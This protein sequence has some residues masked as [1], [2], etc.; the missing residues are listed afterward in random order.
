MQ[1]RLYIATATLLVVTLAALGCHDDPTAPTGPAP[2]E[3]S[4]VLAAATPLSFWQVSGGNPFTCAI[5]AADSSA[6]CWG[7]NDHGELGTGS[8]TGP[9]QCPSAIGP[10]ACSTR[11][12]KVATGTRK[13]RSIATGY[14]HACAVTTD[15]HVWCWGNNDHGQLGAGSSATGSATPLAV[16]GSRRFRQVDA[17][18]Y[19]TCGVSYPD[20][21][22]FCWGNN[23]SGQLGDGTLSRRSAPVATLGGLTVGQVAT[24]QDHSCAVTSTDVA[25]CWGFNSDGQLGDSTRTRRT[26]PVKVVGGH[27]FRQIDAG[28]FHTCAVQTNARP[29]CW[30]NGRKGQTGDGKTRLSLWPRLVLGNLSVG[31]I[32]TGLY[33]TCA[34]TLVKK[35]Y[36]WGD[37]TFGQIGNGQMASGSAVLTPAAV[38]GGLSIGQMSAGAWHTCAKTPGNKGYCWGNNAAGQLG[39]GHS[40]TGVASPTPVAVA[41][42]Q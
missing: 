29:F 12:A 14:L 9:N 28:S 11:P 23:E 1:P 41:A 18:A 38:V 21:R 17:G 30:G 35:A 10:F 36:C 2:S 8:T 33:H 16:A 27:A 34:E 19:H 32:T 7:E 3:A 13:F 31:R 40:G 4:A 15:F 37:N 22:L 6:W 24:G 26:K 25:Y 42:P 20:N 5:A 39:D